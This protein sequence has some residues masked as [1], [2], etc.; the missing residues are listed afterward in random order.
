[1]WCWVLAAVQ[2]GNDWGL[3]GAASLALWGF[4]KLK[5]TSKAHSKAEL[6]SSSILLSHSPPIIRCLH[7]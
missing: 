2:P 7:S 5:I 6:M 3:V 1:M 4:G